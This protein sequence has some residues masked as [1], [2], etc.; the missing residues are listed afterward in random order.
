MKP[1][2]LVEASALEVAEA[3]LE[4]RSAEGQYRRARALVGDLRHSRA[5]NA[6]AR[7]AARRVRD[8]QIALSISLVGYEFVRSAP[9]WVPMNHKLRLSRLE[10]VKMDAGWTAERL[11]E[12]LQIP[13]R[14]LF[15]MEDGM[16]VELRD[17][18]RLAHALGVPLKSLVLEEGESPKDYWRS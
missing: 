11:S 4:L 13:E 15:L 17:A 6:S 5:S 7:G 18:A 3:T 14:T 12:R 9:R 2:G 16:G 1:S 8:A 10:T